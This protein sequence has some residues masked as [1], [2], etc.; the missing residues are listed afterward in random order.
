MRRTV[1]LLLKRD[2][3]GREDDRVVI[4]DRFF[5]LWINNRQLQ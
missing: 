5:R 4:P 3:I 2:I 1:G